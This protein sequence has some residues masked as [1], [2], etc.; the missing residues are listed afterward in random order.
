MRSYAL[1][2][3]A[4]VLHMIEKLTMTKILKL[5][6]NTGQVMFSREIYFY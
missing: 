5:T 6:V 1:L 2:L 3:K 4:A